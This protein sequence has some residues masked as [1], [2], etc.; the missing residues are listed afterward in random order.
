M[1][2]VI[3]TDALTKKYRRVAALDHVNLEVQALP[4]SSAPIPA[5]SAARPIPRSATSPKIRK[6]LNG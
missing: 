5:K 1:T 2:A 6:S 4:K 3:R